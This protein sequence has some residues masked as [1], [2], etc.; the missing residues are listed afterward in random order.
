MR[1]YHRAMKT[2][3]ALIAA[4][5]LT[6]SFAAPAQR[7]P[8]LI[9]AHYEGHDFSAL[10]AC[11]KQTDEARADWNSQ[12]I[13][14][15][16]YYPGI[17][18]NEIKV[19]ACGL[20]NGVKNTWNGFLDFVDAV[21]TLDTYLNLGDALIN[22]GDLLMNAGANLNKAMMSYKQLDEVS[23]K[24]IRCGF[25]VELGGAIGG[26][27]GARAAVTGAVKSIPKVAKFVKGSVAAEVAATESTATTASTALA[28]TYD[29]VALKAQREALKAAKAAEGAGHATTTPAASLSSTYDEVA[30]QAQRE[31][32]K[33]TREAAESTALAL[34]NRAINVYQ[35]VNITSQFDHLMA[36]RAM[37]PKF[38]ELLKTLVATGHISEATMMRM[39]YFAKAA[40]SRAEKLYGPLS[41]KQMK[42]ICERLFYKSNFRS[43][44]VLTHNEIVGLQS[45]KLSIAVDKIL[46]KVTAAGPIKF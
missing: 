45:G 28:T 3:I 23:Q 6:S 29:E 30:L 39:T 2:F 19:C 11:A 1:P 44:E 32:L 16:G 36:A 17:Y 40:I 4:F 35:G 8:G 38:Q 13:K 33:A 27:M 26:G 34:P 14:I 25:W 5:T 43:I 20:S 10:A 37:M 41:A 15:D 42:K 12:L 9:S 7:D 22:S 46:T 21:F 31:A 24:A 18:L